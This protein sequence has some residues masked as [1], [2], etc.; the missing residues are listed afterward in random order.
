VAATNW[1]GFYAGGFLGMAYGNTD[2]RFVGDPLGAGNNPRVAGALGGFEVGYNYQFANRLVLGVEGDI[3]AANLHGARTCGSDN[4]RNVNGV[5]VRFPVAYLNCQNVANW[6]ATVAGRLGYAWGRTLYYVRAGAAFEDDNV[7]VSCIFGPT[8]GVVTPNGI[9]GPCLNQAGAVTNGFS[10][11]GTRTGW[12]IGFGTEFDLG[13]N[14]SA[15]GE[16]DYIDFGSRTAL[17]TDGTTLLRDSGAISQ[18]KV[19][20]NYRFSPGAV[21]AKY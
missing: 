4:G 2:I 3:G 18:V 8:N 9:L 14:W 6:M 16:Y 19:G 5:T 12:L 10:T 15:K 17:A 20:V 21:V 13:H 1:T 7:N 11:S